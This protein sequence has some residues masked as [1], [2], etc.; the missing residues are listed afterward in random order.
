[1]PHH[2]TSYILVAFG[3]DTH[4]YTCINVPDRSNFMKPGA[5]AGTHLV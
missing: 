2:T 5:V 1:M 3:V 4:I